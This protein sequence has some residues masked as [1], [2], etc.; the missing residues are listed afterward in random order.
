M[1][2]TRSQHC[3]R[4]EVKLLTFVLLLILIGFASVAQATYS[5]PASRSIQWQGNVGVKG[6]IPSRTTIYKTLSPT[7]GNDAPAIQSAITTCP[8]GQVVKL[9]AGTF[10][11]SSPITV[12]T[13]VTLRGAG[14][15][16]TIIKGA[17]GMTGKYLIGFNSG[18]STGASLGITGGSSKG[19]S[20]ITTGSA[21]GWNVGDFLLIDQVNNPT[22]DPV[23]TNVGTAGTC[24]WCGRASGTRSLGQM[25]RVAAVPS[26]TTATLEMPL[27]W[28][29]VSNLSPQATKVSGLTLD[30]G[31]EEL[32]VDNSASASSNQS[33]D[34]ATI[35]MYGNSNCW[36]LNVEG[37]GSYTNM[38][39]VKNS[40]RNT[41]R[42]CK[43]HEGTPALPVTGSQYSTSRAYG[44]VMDYSSANLME[45]NQI[46]HLTMG[47]AMRGPTSGNVVSYN[48]ITDMYFSDSM[49][50]QTDSFDFHGGHSVMNLF[51]GNYVAKGRMCADYVWGS[52]S[53]NT[54][55]RNRQA[56]DTT[57]TLA[58]WD[59]SLYKYSTYYNFIGNVI[60][61]PG[62]ES[63]YILQTEDT[64]QKA[65]YG[66]AAL[67]LATVLLHGNWDTI[68]NS[69]SWNS[70]Y[71]RT[72]PASLY[73]SSKPSWWGSTA[74][75]AIGPDASP[76]Y[77]AAPAVG[78]GTPWGTSKPPLSPPTALTVH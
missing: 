39:R 68:N 57:R 14:M 76:M 67:P 7:G 26:S 20:T 77:P 45:N 27:Y 21:H 31:I 47:V 61:T 72:L 37:I 24:S 43:I 34:G 60:G 40:Y 9:S 74:W 59:Y 11:I 32:T 55:F 30:A 41:I 63:T 16:N 75:P 25:A 71:D 35:A 48:Y 22:G 19:S 6:D 70:S 1:S 52:S 64:K 69:V 3:G 54:F 5:L 29:Y 13:G 8:Q 73:L 58:A 42:G 66:F 46:Y 12:K 51:E 56:I 17:S 33:S 38:I 28:N 44:I 62:F 23:V 36:L 49:T 4:S 18:T 53:H 2:T 15:G 10:S 50:W 65:I 78:G